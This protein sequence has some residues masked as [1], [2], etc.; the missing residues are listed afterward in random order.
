M[1]R[2]RHGIPDRTGRSKPENTDIF[3]DIGI[4]PVTFMPEGHDIKHLLAAL[5]KQGLT[6][7]FVESPGDHIS[8]LRVRTMEVLKFLTNPETYAAPKKQSP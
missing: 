3:I 2:P 6:Y 8:H 4:G 7:A 5:D 1:V